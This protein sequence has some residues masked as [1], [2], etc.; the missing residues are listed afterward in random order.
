LRYDLSKL[1]AKGLVVKVDGTHR[2]R[3]TAEGFRLCVLFIKLADRVY[4]PL[5]AAILSPILDHQTLSPEKRAKLDQ[6]YAAIDH[7]ISMLLHQLG[8]KA[9]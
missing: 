8:L 5:T 9:A 4:K 3:L 6:H 1:R 7:A 2:Y